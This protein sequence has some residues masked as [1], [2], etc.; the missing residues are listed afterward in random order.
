MVRVSLTRIS[1]HSAVHPYPSDFCDT[2]SSRFY[3]RIKCMHSVKA[4][5]CICLC[6]RQRGFM[7]GEGLWVKA[8]VVWP[9]NIATKSCLTDLIS[10]ECQDQNIRSF[11][12]STSGKGK[13]SRW[14]PNH[15]NNSKLIMT[16]SSYDQKPKTWGLLGKF[17][18]SYICGVNGTIFRIVETSDSRW[19][20][21]ENPKWLPK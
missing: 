20:Q 1:E 9:R 18:L 19:F 11:R 13:F 21:Y 12:N 4:V 10:T 5:Y 15:S 6:G 17:R 3:Y 16:W 14:P 7:N 8:C 2:L